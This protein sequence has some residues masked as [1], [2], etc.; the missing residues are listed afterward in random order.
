[1]NIFRGKGGDCVTIFYLFVYA[2]P[3]LFS[4][5]MSSKRSNKECR[6]LAMSPNS[7]CRI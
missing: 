6:F 2:L 7:L 3:F 5:A 1:M 4:L